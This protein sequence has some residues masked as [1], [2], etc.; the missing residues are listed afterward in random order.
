MKHRRIAFSLL[1]VFLVAVAVIAQPRRPGTSSV[2]P[3]EKVEVV[4]DDDPLA[5]FAEKGLPEPA[6]LALRPSAELA[7][8]VAPRILKNDPNSLAVLTGALQKAG[9]YIID[10]NQKVL[11]RP[12]SAPIG[13]AFYDFEVAGMLRGTGFGFATTLEKISGLIAN[14]GNLAQSRFSSLLLDDLRT[15]RTSKDPQTQFIA[16][17]IFELGKGLSDLSTGTPAEARLNLIQA[18]LIERIFLGDLMDAFERF[19]EQ[20]ASLLPARRVFGSDRIV[21]YLPA[22]LSRIQPGPCEA[23]S[24]VST[25]AG[26]EGKI[27][28]LGGTIFDKKAIPSFLTAPKE[29]IKQQ[30]EKL[31]KGIGVANVVMSWAKLIMANMNIYAVITVEVPSL[32][33]IRTKHNIREGEERTVTAKFGIDFKDSETVNCVGKAVKTVTGFSVEVPKDGPMRNVPVKWWAVE[34]GTGYSKFTE[35]PVRIEPLDGNS[36]SRQVTNDVGENKIKL[37]GLKQKTN[38]E[39]LPVVPRAKN[40]S[41]RVSVAT[42][43]MDAKK[44]I[45]KLFGLGFDSAFDFFENA[46]GLKQVL[47]MLPDMFAK[48]ALKT[49]KVGVPVRDWQPCSDDWGGYINY[50]KKLSK[51]VVVRSSRSSNGNSTG[52]GVRRIEKEAT[53]S[54]VLNPRTPEDVEANKPLRPADYRVRGKYREVFEG[55]R[56]ADP[57]CGPEEGAFATKFRTGSITDFFGSFQAPFSLSFSGGD[58]DYSLGFHFM[59]ESVDAHQ[60]EFM[61]IL[62]TNCPLEYA[63]ESSKDTDFPMFLEDDLAPGRYPERLS[64]TAGDLLKGSKEVPRPDGSIITWD[65]ELARCK[66]MR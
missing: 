31:A 32:P 5:N 29:A 39:G 6:V 19:S 14:D 53:V 54:V 1:F 33:L 18:S 49:Y 63:E 58:R 40:A 2:P 24:D 46:F 60:Y 26:Y 22:S 51:T 66:Q 37:T 25:V 65:W 13:A 20:N 27:K 48:M 34:E 36:I 23:I 55:S 56:E 38:L 64:N 7:R 9:F 11:Y 62:E 8:S 41:L 30:F 57:C 4:T 52:D 43:N 35:Y 42:E 16:T 12:T 44:D 28:K 50:K 61:E 59:T 45:P 3:P 21:S 17:L 10:T 15:A 47:G